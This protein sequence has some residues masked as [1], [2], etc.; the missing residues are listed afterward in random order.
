MEGATALPSIIRA[1]S[2]VMGRAYT[3]LDQ[4]ARNQL[5]VS[6]SK[7]VKSGEYYSPVGVAGK[8]SSNG[9]SDNL[10]KK[11]WD[12]TQKELEPHLF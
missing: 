5:W 9:K 6:V 11:L 1:I 10:A 4:G 7:D 12:W 8:A 3:P 2:R